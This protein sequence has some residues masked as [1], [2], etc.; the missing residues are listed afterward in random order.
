[1]ADKFQL[2]ALITGVDKLTPMLRGIQKN[3]MNM[4]KKLAKSGL[5]NLSFGEIAT[6]G[7]LAAPFIVAAKQAMK[8]E[9][10]MADV[11]KV[12]DFET[13]QQ[14]AQMRKDI[15][16]MSTEL[17]MAAEG[18]AQ[19]VAAGGQAGIPRAELKGFARDAVKMG[20]AFDQTADEAGQMMKTWRTAFRI[21]QSDVVKLA[22]QINYLG[23]T[24]P[25]NAKQISAIVTSIGPLGEVAGLASGQVA[26][27]GATLVGMGVAEEVAATGMKNFMLTMTA[28]AAATKKQQETFRALRLDARQI[29]QGM[30][31]DAQGAIM[32]VLT[33]VGK[34][35]KSQHAAVLTR[36]FGRESVAAITPM[37]TNLDLLQKNFFKVGDATQYA[38]SME[39]E[40]AARAA[41]TEN[42]LQLLRGQVMRLAVTVGDVLLP[43]FNQFLAAIGPL[44]NRVAEF[45]G[46]HPGLIKGLM[47][48]V[49]AFM[50]LRLGV[51]GFSVALKLLNVSPVMLAI[52]G[53]ALAAGFLIANWGSIGPFF[54]DLWERIKGYAQAAWDLFKDVVSFTP[55]ALITRNWEPIVAFFKGLWERVSPI[56]KGLF[57]GR[58][59]QP[60]VT[61]NA[62]AQMIG[63]PRQSPLGAAQAAQRQQV[64]GEINVHFTNPPPGTTVQTAAPQSGVKVN[65][66]VG[67]RSLAGAY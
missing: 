27:M 20:V 3:A 22:D 23:N 64:N 26:A 25:A 50:A 6:G 29:A 21:G 9:S 61:G 30:Q 45:A 35:D 48:A 58:N 14:F 33:A 32:R 62:Y 53:I 24:G 65:S 60:T 11:K 44:I 46:Q 17:P 12:V 36:L 31:T 39:K 63:S 55:L 2:K 38:G 49:G 42:N 5:G 34:V 51:L 66:N 67:R 41:T 16:Q 47:G 13:P 56:V 57:G 52:T 40:Y 19:I 37:L 1:M 43:P 7:A 18:I 15:L 10:N 4:R 28:G 59:T 8:F 54:S